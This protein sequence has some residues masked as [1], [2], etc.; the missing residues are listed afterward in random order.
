MAPDTPQRTTSTPPNRSTDLGLLHRIGTASW[1]R[2]A[3]AAMAVFTAVGAAVTR[4]WAWGGWV[5]EVLT[6]AFA[7]AAALGHLLTQWTQSAS[8]TKL[9]QKK[10]DSTRE[11]LESWQPR[12]EQVIHHGNSQWQRGVAKTVRDNSLETAFNLLKALGLKDHRLCLYTLGIPED[13]NGNRDLL[14][15]ETHFPKQARLAPTKSFR[16][17]EPAAESLFKCIDE[18]RAETTGK[19]D[20]THRGNTEPQPS[21]MASLRV[22]VV[23]DGSARGVLTV[24]S[25]KAS[26]W[27][28]EP[29]YTSVVEFASAFLA[30]AYLNEDS[31]TQA[32]H[33]RDVLKNLQEDGQRTAE[34]DHPGT[35]PTDSSLGSTT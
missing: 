2:W 15:Y 22:P 10:F 7:L 11:C 35:T 3:V 5:A 31:G 6:I 9:E 25:P 24:D 1:L 28:A 16:R 27:T 33:A 14:T 21:W 13:A 29:A 12:F 34:R 18:N 8:Q 23:I 30:Q 4:V 19:R 26:G 20:T 17:S 32:G